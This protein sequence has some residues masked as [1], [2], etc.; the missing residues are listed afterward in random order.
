MS[1]SAEVENNAFFIFKQKFQQQRT[2]Y[3]TSGVARSNR[4]YHADHGAFSMLTNISRLIEH[5]VLCDDIDEFRLQVENN[6]GEINSCFYCDKD[7]GSDTNSALCLAVQASFSSKYSKQVACYVSNT[8]TLTNI[9]CIV[10]A[11]FDVTKNHPS[12]K[13][14]DDMSSPK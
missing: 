8:D 7:P 1:F 9:M 14:Y 11:I 13:S 2:T 10:L 6:K 12:W 3:I 5:V 4:V